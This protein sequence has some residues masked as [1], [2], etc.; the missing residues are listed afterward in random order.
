MVLS[1]V[2]KGNKEVRSMQVK[3]R[4][5]LGLLVVSFLVISLLLTGFWFI[6]FSNWVEIER[7]L[8]IIIGV[9]FSVLFF[10]SALGIGA[11][12]FA[13]WAKKPVIILQNSIRIAINLL[14]PLII[15]I[16]KLMDLE[17]EE[18]EHSFIEV[19][20]QLVRNKNIVLPPER[21]LILLPHCLQK[22]NCPHKIT[23]D[24]DNC[25][26]CGG[27][28][29]GELIELAKEYQIHLAIVTGGTAARKML[30]QIK[31]KAVVAVACERDLISGIQDAYP[32]PVLGILNE[33]PQGP[34]YNTLVNLDQVRSSL[35]YLLKGDTLNC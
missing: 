19:N 15:K 1:W 12:I 3:K 34:C 13:L 16:G 4:L 17:K 21:I 30:Q 35:E 5:Y 24:I 28:R 29:I 32:L 14:S 25:Q 20:N 23:I 26:H 6:L 22:A 7:Q 18:I 31:P 8:L 9:V 10:A 2:G 33:R 27:C 11:I